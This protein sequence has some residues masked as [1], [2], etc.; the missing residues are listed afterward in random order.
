MRIFKSFFVF[1]ILVAINI[2]LHSELD[3]IK[4]FEKNLIV[5]KYVGIAS[6]GK[7]IL[8]WGN[9]NEV[10]RSTDMGNNWERKVILDDYS[11]VWLEYVGQKY[12]G[13]LNKHFAIVSKDEGRTWELFVL[14]EQET[15]YRGFWYKNYFYYMTD[16]KFKMLDTNF[17][18]VKEFSYTKDTNSYE[19]VVGNN[20][21]IYPIGNGKIGLINIQNKETKIIDLKQNNVCTDC[22]LPSKFLSDDNYFYFL[23]K[24]FYY[25]YNFANQN[26]TLIEKLNNPNSSAFTLWKGNLYLIYSSWTNVNLDSLIF[27]KLTP[28]KE[29]LNTSSFDRRVVRST[30]SKLKFV[31]D[32]VVVAVGYGKF[33]CFSSN[34]GKTWAVKSFGAFPLT[35]QNLF[36]ID[37]LNLRAIDNYH[38][39][40]YTTNGGVTWLP[41]KNYPYKILT[42]FNPYQEMFHYFFDTQ[43]GISVQR[44]QLS[45]DS[46][47]ITT[48]DKGE[49]L[50]LEHSTD[51]N[52]LEDSYYTVPLGDKL[53]VFTNNAMSDYGIWFIVWELDKNFSFYKKSYSLFRQIFNP[54]KTKNYIVGFSI[55]RPKGVTYGEPSYW[56][57][58]SSNLGLTWDSIEVF[59]EYWLNSQWDLSNFKTWAIGDDIYLDFNLFNINTQSSFDVLYYFN[60]ETN[61]FTLIETDT[62]DYVPYAIFKVGNKVF[63]TKNRFDFTKI[64][65]KIYVFEDKIHF[66]EFEISNEQAIPL[67][68]IPSNFDT[69]LFALFF[70]DTTANTS[71]TYL[72]KEANTSSVES[73]VEKRY[74]TTK[75]WASEPYPQPAGV[76]VKA[77]IAWDG[78][79]DVG[80]A[81]DGVYDSMGRKVEGKERIRITL[82]DKGY[83]ELEWE[84][85]GV[86]AGVYFVL[87]RWAGG[88]ESVP[89]VVE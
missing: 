73:Q 52:Y 61:E 64:Y 44:K 50:K 46:N 36:I 67:T 40:F 10:I 27:F 20:K 89:V 76:R 37:S 16:S 80:E 86:P 32:S 26:F 75:F 81:I 49:T 17:N 65:F 47:I 55:A 78:S 87:L 88:S 21:I 51:F 53:L 41:T 34:G 72:V 48:R 74:Y 62:T 57:I 43:N 25:R 77:R 24:N 45:T 68:V 82:R 38:N 69:N 18:L 29:K 71:Y 83:G 30:F 31:D 3:I 28:G 79:F 84:C 9:T 11:I 19:F 33:V 42:Q 12:V 35:S 14:N 7:S 70:I 5:Y 59:K 56:I 63:Y 66:K 6:S 58:K 39:F 2:N 1:L 23:V 8:L 22:N 4:G 60:P 54:Q 13:F 15:I 85:S